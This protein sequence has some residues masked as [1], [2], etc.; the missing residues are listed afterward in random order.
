M[1]QRKPK[2]VLRA[3]GINDFRPGSDAVVLLNGKPHVVSTD[4]TYAPVP[5]HEPPIETFREN[6]EKLT[7]EQRTKMLACVLKTP[8]LTPEGRAARVQ[9][10]VELGARIAFEVVPAPRR[11]VSLVR[12]EIDLRS[13]PALLRS[14]D[15]T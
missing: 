5:V 3:S 1:A 14:G 10:L 4:A 9:L 7:V 15:G 8:F 12:S 11:R 6:A 13:P 2:G